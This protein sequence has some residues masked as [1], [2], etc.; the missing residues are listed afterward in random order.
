MENSNQLP[1]PPPALPSNWGEMTGDEKREYYVAG[2]AGVEGKNF[3]S[4]E[5]EEKYKKRTQRLLDAIA[6]KEPD[7]VPTILLTEGFVVEHG[8]CNHADTFYNYDKYMPAA[9][10]FQ[11][12][13]KD[14]LDYS[15]LTYGQS[16]VAYD[17]LGMKLIRWPGGAGPDG[18][19]EHAQFQYVE[20]EYMLEDEYDE[21]IANPEGYMMRTYLP[22]ICSN[23]GGLATVPNFMNYVEC[24]AFSGS[25]FAMSKGMPTR[26]AFELMFEAAD[27]VADN[28]FKLFATAATI[29]SR[30]GTPGIIGGIT[31]SPFD[32]IGDT[33]RCTV[34]MMK[35]LYRQPDKVLAAVQALVPLS[36]KMGASMVEGSRC[37]IILIPLHKGAD[38][39]MSPQ[40]F[41][42]FY[43]PALKATILGLIDAGCIPLPVIEGSYNQRFDIMAA[44]PLPKGKV[45]FMLDRSDMKLAKEKIGDWAS[46]MGNVPASLF[47]QGSPQDLENYVKDLCETCM[48]GGG[49]CLSPGA[50][51][52]QAN[53]ENI[54]AFL[55][56][57][58]KYGKY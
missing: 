40:Q 26:Q 11:E 21:L 43:W 53:A 14:D 10:K 48:P 54:S 6:H 46:L 47:R 8:G 32:I 17:L 15:I 18:L 1:P 56:C 58:K 41:E 37:P 2:W 28:M 31:Y 29:T 33:M 4:P 49:F 23:L 57:G 25:L 35:D 52:D 19:P 9:L 7:E 34:G 50:M 30:Y 3:D 51:I 38:G 44:D 5:I 12:D 27:A 36:I 42:K 45:M 16:G 55:Q 39:F 13:F 24:P 22:R 20:K